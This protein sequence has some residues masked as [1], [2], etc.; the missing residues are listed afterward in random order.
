[1]IFLTVEL[2]TGKHVIR[3]GETKLLSDQIPLM[4]FDGDLCLS[5]SGGKLASLTLTTHINSPEMTADDNFKMLRDLRKY[6]ECWE[7]C[8]ALN[9]QQDWI[10]FAEAAIADLD[11]K[12]GKFNYYFDRLKIM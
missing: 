7:L 5:G 8:R 11:T 4:L 10:Q 12:L 3:A 2:I 1:M 6:D 9:N